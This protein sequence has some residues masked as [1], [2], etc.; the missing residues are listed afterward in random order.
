MS[1]FVVAPVAEACA[2]FTVLFCLMNHHQYQ[3]AAWYDAAHRLTVGQRLLP[4]GTWQTAQPE[5][6]WL[7][8]RGRFAHITDFDS[9]NYLTLAVDGAGFIHL[10]GNMHVDPLIYFRSQTPLDITT[11]TCVP[12]MTGERETRATYPVFFKDAQGRLLFRYRDGCSGNGD[13]I[14]NIYDTDSQRWTRLLETPLLNGEG[15]R[16]GYARQPLCG[17]D[18]YWHMVWMWRETPRCETNNNLSYARSRDLQHWEKSDGTPLTLPI[19]RHQ[20]EIVDGADINGGLINMVQEVGFDNA[21]RPVLIYH[22]YDGCGSSQAFLARPNGDGRWQKRQISEW[23]FRWD[24]SGGGSIPPDVTLSAPRPIGEGKMEVEWTSLWAGKGIW[25]IDDRTLTI[26]ATRALHRPIPETQYLPRQ[27]IAP[28]AEVQLIAAL[29]SDYSPQT[30]D[31]LRWEALPIF[32][33]VP[34]EGKTGATQLEV[35]TLR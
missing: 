12:S 6:F 29:N 35:L 31:W 15:E 19:A 22:R 26:V 1:N 25:I 2:D 33:D 28:R 34:H 24:F 13:D 18:G 9:H 7:P 11:L 27:H 17:P 32:R 3:Y 21:G 10:S 8:E 4:N 30:R 5:G 20:G 16:N 14:Y 23:D